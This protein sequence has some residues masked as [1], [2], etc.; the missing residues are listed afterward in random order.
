[1]SSILDP[2]PLTPWAAASQVSDSASPL[3][4]ALSV[5]YRPKSKN[6]IVYLGDSNTDYGATDD[7]AMIAYSDRGFSTWGQVL[8]GHRLEVL[9]NAGIQGE[10]TD[11]IRA[12]IPSNV[13]A[14]AP[15]WCHVLAGTNDMLQ[16]IPLATAKANLLGIWNDLR[17][18]GIRVIAATLPPA[19]GLTTSRQAFLYDLN[20]WIKLQ[21]SVIPDLTVVDYHRVLADPAT[22]GWYSN[23]ALS[24]GLHTARPGAAAMGK[25]LADAINVLVPPRPRLVGTTND[26]FNLLP[27]PMLTGNTSGVAT[28]WT[29]S[30]LA[31]G[32]GTATPT[33]VAR[34][35]GLPGEMQQMVVASGQASAGFILQAFTPSTIN[36]TPGDTV[37]ATAEVEMGDDVANFQYLRLT[38]MPTTA[39]LAGITPF[40]AD[41]DPYQQS[42][43]AAP[44]LKIS[45]GILRTRALATPVTAAR[46]MVVL[47]YKGEGTIRVGSIALI[48]ATKLAARTA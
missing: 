2:K 35:D 31:G 25:A 39:A 6:T 44:A 22:N 10:R 28:G 36:F 38:I 43:V 46:V 47:A 7:P 14:Q 48:N 23:Y 34:T 5:A 12:R 16:D 42:I 37:F 15:G 32:A 17:A 40:A 8:T 29:H 18:A 19:T 21:G 20:A 4:A 1:M 30:T 26:P 13:I 45:K 11:Q 41:M 33:K 27:N 24:D 9:T 3:G